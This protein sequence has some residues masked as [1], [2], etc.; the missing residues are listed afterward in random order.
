MEESKKWILGQD[1]YYLDVVLNCI[2]LGA[3]STLELAQIALITNITTNVIIYNPHC[4]G[5][6]GT[7]KRGKLILDY[8]L[9]TNGM[10]DG[11]DLMFIAQG[12]IPMEGLRL[13]AVKVIDENSHLLKEVLIELKI[14]NALF[15]EAFEIEVTERDLNG[16]G[17]I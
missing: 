15:M 3:D 13:D 4:T 9:N 10:T 2:H 1:D 5:L 7:L 6:G 16:N 14:S 11:D 12:N 17:I 8:D